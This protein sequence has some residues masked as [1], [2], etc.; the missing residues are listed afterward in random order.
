MSI[1][2]PNS[3]ILTTRPDANLLD[4][5]Q[6]KL[7]TS[8][9][10]APTKSRSVSSQSENV[11]TELEQTRDTRRELEITPGEVHAAYVELNGRIPENGRP[12]RLRLPGVPRAARPGMPRE[13]R[14]ASGVIALHQQLHE[15]L[16][17]GVLI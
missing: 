17:Y 6:E 13:F 4:A 2:S 8:P 9:A 15:F 5:N 3:T 16:D 10:L 12:L 11:S 1:S 14:D 7:E